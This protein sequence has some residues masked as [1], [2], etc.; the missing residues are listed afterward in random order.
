MKPRIPNQ[1]GLPSDKQYRTRERGCSVPWDTSLTSPCPLTTFSQR[2]SIPATGLFVPDTIAS[3]QGDLRAGLQRHE[4]DAACVP[5][6]YLRR[7]RRHSC[8]LEFRPVP[9][10]LLAHHRLPLCR[11]HRV[12]GRGR[13]AEP[14]RPVYRLLRL[15]RRKLLDHLCGY[16]LGGSNAVAKPR[17]KGREFSAPYGI[18]DKA[19]LRTRTP[20]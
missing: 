4:G 1:F 14:S 5:A 12:C 13:H 20:R 3:S 2:R 6:V 11:G 9:R 7:T 16:K 15:P 17:E 18:P 10:T 8:C 19:L